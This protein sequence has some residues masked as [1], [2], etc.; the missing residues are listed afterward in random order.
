MLTAKRTS[1]SR[2]RRRLVSLIQDV[3][4]GQIQGLTVRKGEP[5][6]E[7]MPRV[8]RSIRLGQPRGDSTEHPTGNFALKTEVAD[9]LVRLSELRDG[10][11]HR[12][13]VKNGLPLSLVV[14]AADPDKIPTP[15]GRR[16]PE[17]R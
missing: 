6:F 12:I 10:V 11:V 9:M 17:S 4:F 16:D 7:P 1:L 5:V 13:D 15:S 3:G 8:L 14:E 2:G